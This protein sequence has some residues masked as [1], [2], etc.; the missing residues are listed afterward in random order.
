[1]KK[2]LMILALTLTSV[3]GNAQC[4]KPTIYPGGTYSNERLYFSFN[5]NGFVFGATDSVKYTSNGLWKTIP[6]LSTYNAYVPVASGSTVKYVV[7]YYCSKP[8]KVSDTATYTASS[9]VTP[10]APSSVTVRIADGGWFVKDSAS[11]TCACGTYVHRAYLVTNKGNIL[12]TSD[13]MTIPYM[14]H[15][16]CI[17]QRFA[18]DNGIKNTAAISYVFG[19]QSMSGG[20]SSAETLSPAFL[21]PDQ[22]CIYGK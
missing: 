19:V 12:A 11:T 4:N 3:V 10:T 14:D 13:T 6:A 21:F 15:S 20:V 8:A 18:K 5:N 1:M 7:A 9:S 17:L 16:F 2:L 22:Q